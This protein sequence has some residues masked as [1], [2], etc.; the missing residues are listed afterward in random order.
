MTHTDSITANPLARHPVALTLRLEGLVIGGAAVIAYGPMG[1]SWMLF[2]LLLLSPDLL[3]LG[4]LA[5]NR[6][7]AFCYNMAHSY[8]GPVGLGLYGFLAGLDLG[9]QLAL[10]WAAH[11]GLDRAM[12]YGL[13]YAAGF[14]Q[15][16]LNRV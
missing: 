5:G 11:I 7:G 3:M 2:A 4:Y 16:H 15:T 1:G 10:I 13:K 9:L 14:R 8:L 6:A 12:G